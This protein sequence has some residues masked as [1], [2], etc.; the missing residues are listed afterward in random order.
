MPAPAEEH[1][2]EAEQANITKNILIFCTRYLQLLA[3]S[4]GLSVRYIPN[5]EKLDMA[6]SAVSV[7]DTT[8]YVLL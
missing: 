7:F 8:G 1:F 6:P 2:L 3:A 4:I 5:K